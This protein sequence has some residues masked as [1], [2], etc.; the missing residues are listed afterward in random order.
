MIKCVTHSLVLIFFSWKTADTG[1]CSWKGSTAVFSPQFAERSFACVLHYS[2]SL[3]FV[4]FP[5]RILA[6]FFQNSFKMVFYF[7]SN[8]VNPPVTFFMGLDK[9]ESKISEYIGYVLCPRFLTPLFLAFADEEL[10]RWGWPEDVWFHVD[11]ISSAHVYIRLQKVCELD[12]GEGFLCRF[13]VFPYRAK[14]LMTSPLQSW[15]ML[16]NL[17]RPTAYRGTK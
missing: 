4:A 10:I 16:V 5:H 15:T 13:N 12:K 1:S 6:H 2:I 9:F 7:T 8:V 14:P 11:K 3:F 17:S